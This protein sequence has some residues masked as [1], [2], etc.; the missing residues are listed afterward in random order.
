VRHHGQA[1]SRPAALHSAGKVAILRRLLADPPVPMLAQLATAL[2]VGPDWRY[3]PKL[4]GFRAL[5]ARRCDGSVR[6]TSRNQKDLG[7]WFPEV[8]EAARWLPPGTLLD[9][10]LILAD[11]NG[12]ADFGALQARPGRL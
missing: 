12:H 1:G 3:E 4:D 2:P 5:L 6:L 10:E 7:R 8:L 11:E 9:G